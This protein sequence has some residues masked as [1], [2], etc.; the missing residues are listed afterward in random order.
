MRCFVFNMRVHANLKI[1]YFCVSSSLDFEGTI[2][3]SVSVY[4]LVVGIGLLQSSCVRGWLKPENLPLSLV[5][6]IK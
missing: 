6:K 2:A 3:Q 1:T 5:N 4:L